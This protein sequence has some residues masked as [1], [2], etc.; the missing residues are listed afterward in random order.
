MLKLISAKSLVNHPIYRTICT[1]RT[2]LKRLNNALAGAFSY[3]SD[4]QHPF[5]PPT[6][7]A[8]Q[9]DIF[10]KSDLVAIRWA[11]A[12]GAAQATA[13]LADGHINTSIIPMLDDTS[14]L[15][16]GITNILNDPAV[17]DLLNRAR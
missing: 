12:I 5:T 8:M 14:N 9:L 17:T 6:Q 7:D 2:S 15:T 11:I 1:L 13:L 10:V 16:Q 4:L 3:L